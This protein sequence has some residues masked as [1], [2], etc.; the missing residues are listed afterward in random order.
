MHTAFVVL[1]LIFN[2]LIDIFVKIPYLSLR[3]ISLAY[4]QYAY[5]DFPCAKYGLSTNLSII[6]LKISIKEKL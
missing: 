6:R 3:Q 1:I 4:I 2:L 5:V